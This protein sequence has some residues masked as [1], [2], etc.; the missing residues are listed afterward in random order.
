MPATQLTDHFCDA[1][2]YA[3]AA[4]GGQVRKGTEVPYLS[5]LLAVAALVLEDGGSETEAIILRDYGTH[6]EALWDRFN[7]RA[8]QLCYLRA[9]TDA[10][11]ACSS[12]PMVAD[13][14]AAVTELEQRTGDAD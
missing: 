4:H 5:H 2:A 3:A 11:D 7:G 13:L 12:S 6:G 8:G 9:L 1:V 14:Q 10:F